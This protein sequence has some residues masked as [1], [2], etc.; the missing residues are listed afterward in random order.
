MSIELVKR[1]MCSGPLVP[2]LMPMI[3][4]R[5]QI[6]LLRRETGQTKLCLGRRVVESE[7]IPVKEIR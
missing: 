1:A 4:S 2:E 6:D 5:A 3:L 7:L